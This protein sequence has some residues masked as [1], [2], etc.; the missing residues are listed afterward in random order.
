[1]EYDDKRIFTGEE[2]EAILRAL[3][4]REL[5]QVLRATYR[6]EGTKIVKLIASRTGRIGI[7][8]GEKMARKSLRVF[9]YSKGGGFMVTVKPRG[10][11]GLFMTRQ[12]K[13]APSKRWRYGHPVGMW[14]N[15]GSWRTGNRVTQTGGRRG[16]LYGYH[17]VENGEHDAVIMVRKDV[18][19]DL[20]TTLQKRMGKM[21]FVLG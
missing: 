20:K 11:K 15:S 2:F 5:R 6:K 4:E 8:D 13:T 1:M 10:K 18:M 9:T 19:D 17:F 21:G 3:N 12:D 16:R 14:L 7:R